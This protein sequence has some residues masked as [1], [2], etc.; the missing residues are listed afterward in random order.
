M[1]GRQMEALRDALCAAFDQDSLDQMIRFRLDRN[2]A[3][4]T[5]S[6]NLRTVVFKVIEAAVKEGWQSDLI[7]EALSYNPGNL[8]L[9]QFTEA[10]PNLVRSNLEDKSGNPGLRE[11]LAK[12]VNPS[13]SGQNTR[14]LC[15]CSPQFLT[16]LIGSWEEFQAMKSEAAK[17][18]QGFGGTSSGTGSFVEAAGVNSAGFTE[19]LLDNDYDVIQAGLYV[20]PHSGRV[21][22]SGFDQASCRPGDGAE[23]SISVEVFA[24]HIQRSK[25]KLVI[26]IACDSLVV[27][28][29]LFKFTNV[30]AT[31]Q[32]VGIPAI[33][34]WEKLFW[35]RLT[36][37]DSL[38][39]AFETA[40][41]LSGQSM[42]L[43][44]TKDLSLYA[45]GQSH[46]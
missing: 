34:A 19:V 4:L 38:A 30:I 11:L 16:G 41:A 10:N 29:R 37:G 42:V 6:G 9:R 43:L 22:F 45:P 39:M 13:I 40:N 31:S 36:I 33:M 3:A 2:R 15:V 12:D 17:F 32:S 7:R 20:H 5:P 35:Q 8:A 28:A 27:A 26:M 14:I 46:S 24:A 25:A 18:C 1:T 44:M 21:Y 23:D